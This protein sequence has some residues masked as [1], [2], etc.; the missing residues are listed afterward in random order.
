MS[1]ET[2]SKRIK[3]LPLKT[4]EIQMFIGCSNLETVRRWIR[5]DSIPGSEYQEKI[6][7]LERRFLVGN[8]K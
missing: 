2:W 8:H 1:E 7:E 4:K 6:R 5:E 3:N